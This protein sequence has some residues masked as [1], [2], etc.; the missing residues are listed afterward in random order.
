MLCSRV[1]ERASPCCGAGLGRGGCG[2]AFT[3]TSPVTCISVS[4][5]PS[6][7]GRGVPRGGCSLLNPST[8]FLGAMPAHAGLETARYFLQFRCKFSHWRSAENFSRWLHSFS[9][10]FIFLYQHAPAERAL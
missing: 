9:K 7:H 1:W 8:G 5:A 4:S 2:A 10:L 6:G 3:R